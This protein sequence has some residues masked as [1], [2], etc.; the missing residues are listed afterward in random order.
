MVMFVISV[1]L[2]PTVESNVC[3]KHQLAIWL[4]CSFSMVHRKSLMKSR[5]VSHSIHQFHISA[6]FYCMQFYAHTQIKP[7]ADQYFQID[8]EH[9]L[10]QFT[11]FSFFLCIKNVFLA[12]LNFNFS[13]DFN[14]LLRIN[15]VVS[16][17]VFCIIKY[18]ELHHVD[19]TSLEPIQTIS[20]HRSAWLK[21]S[22]TTTRL[23]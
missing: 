4:N 6:Q 3:I 22:A 12:F 21:Y 7:Y 14:I 13:Y 18:I 20:N 15:I 17:Q 9:D 1:P 23:F 10:R 5:P 2:W 16:F 11:F 8:F 19:H